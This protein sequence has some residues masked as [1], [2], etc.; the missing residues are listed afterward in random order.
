MESRHCAV[1]PDITVLAC[2]S[3]SAKVNE[4]DP[5]GYSERGVCEVISTPT[6]LGPEGPITD[7][8]LQ[9]GTEPNGGGRE[10]AC[11]CVGVRGRFVR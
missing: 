6:Q 3:S 11:V 10:R 7:G 1:G 9:V 8:T 2:G 4:V 5:Y